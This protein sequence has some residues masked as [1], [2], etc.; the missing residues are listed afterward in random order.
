MRDCH[1]I[2]GPTLSL[3]PLCLSLPPSLPPCACSAGLIRISSTPV[4]DPETGAIFA[5]AACGEDVTDQVRAEEERTKLRAAEQ[6]TANISQL[7]ANV[8]HELRSPLVRA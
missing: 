7:M 6:A 3:P 1:H 5:A 2:P 4:R 8:S